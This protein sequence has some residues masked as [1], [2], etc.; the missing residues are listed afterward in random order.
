M[1]LPIAKIRLGPLCE[2]QSYAYENEKRPNR[3]LEPCL[4][5]AVNS[6]SRGPP[7][8]PRHRNVP[9]R[10]HRIEEQPKR[11]ESGDLRRRVDINELRKEGKK[12]HRDFRVQHVRQNALEEYLS[13]A[14]G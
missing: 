7:D 4:H 12:E 10:A 1:T 5:V 11:D 3:T 6:R 13:K 2:S 14:I 9:R 8:E